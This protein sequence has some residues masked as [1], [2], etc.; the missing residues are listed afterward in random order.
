[1]YPTEKIC[2]PRINTVGYTENAYIPPNIIIILITPNPDENFF[3]SR[4]DFWYFLRKIFLIIKSFQLTLHLK[5]VRSKIQNSTAAT[6]EFRILIFAINLIMA[7]FKTQNSKFARRRG[8]IDIFEFCY[9]LIMVL[10][11]IKNSAAGAA[12]FII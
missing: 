6:V 7:K 4:H 9:Q 1:M 5:I 10:S 3:V 8:R 11:K 12:E 2:T